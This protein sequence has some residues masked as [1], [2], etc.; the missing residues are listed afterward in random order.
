MLELEVV[1]VV[2]GLGAET[3][4]LDYDLHLLGLDLLGLALLLVEELLVVGNAAYGR[5][6]LGRYLDQVEL[7][8]LSHGQCLPYRYDEIGLYVLAHHAHHGCRD[9]VVDTVGILLFG[10]SAADSCVVLVSPALIGLR[11]ERFLCDCQICN[12][13]FFILFLSVAA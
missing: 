4:L 1:V 12:C 6:R 5:I 11:R 13:W 9:F 10:T 3:Y 8:L 7:H 2:V